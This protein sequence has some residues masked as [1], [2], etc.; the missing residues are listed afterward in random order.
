MTK[1]KT[2]LNTQEA[3]EQES[4]FVFQTQIKKEISDL[5]EL[6]IVSNP[7]HF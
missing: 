2:K 7:D 3:K 1:L 5:K 6:I 4:V